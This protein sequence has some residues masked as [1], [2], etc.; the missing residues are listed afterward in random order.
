[1]WQREMPG[2]QEVM[3]A[4]HGSRECFAARVQVVELGMPADQQRKPD[5]WKQATNFGMPERRAL[6]PRWQV[7]SVASPGIAH[8][9][10]HHADTAQIVKPFAIHLQPLPEPLATD[11]IPRHASGMD[12]DAWC[13]ADNQK[14]RLAVDSQYRI[15]SQRQVGL[16]YTASPNLLRNN[17]QSAARIA[18]AILVYH[19]L[20]F[21]MEAAGEQTSSSM[22]LGSAHASGNALSRLGVGSASA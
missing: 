6:R 7:A 21:A 10:R 19:F 1:M 8:A 15:G 14:S 22:C 2:R 20:I 11:V 9:H 4:A 3:P 5:F 16:T 17:R 12:F 18:W 13:V